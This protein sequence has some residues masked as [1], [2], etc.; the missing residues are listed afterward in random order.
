VQTHSDAVGEIEWIVSVDS[1]IVRAHQH[2]AGARHN[3]GQADQKKGSGT[4]NQKRW[5]EA[6]ED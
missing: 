1:S 2:A 5:D 6:G 3:P 4:R